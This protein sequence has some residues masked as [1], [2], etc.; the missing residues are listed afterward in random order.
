MKV[1]EKAVILRI[2][3]ARPKGQKRNENGPN[4]GDFEMEKIKM[5]NPIVEMDGDEMTRI[6]WAMIKDQLLTPYVELNTKYYDLG[7][8]NRDA[9]DDQVTIDAGYAIKR[10]HVGVKC[11]TITPNAQRMT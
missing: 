1:R 7:L 2:S 3:G 5:Q 6:L 8:P 9:T 10:Y 11:A 4:K